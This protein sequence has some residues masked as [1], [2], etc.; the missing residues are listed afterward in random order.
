MGLGLTWSSDLDPGTDR[1][2]EAMNWKTW[3]KRRVGNGAGKGRTQSCKGQ[4][5]RPGKDAS[6]KGENPV[7]EAGSAADGICE[8]CQPGQRK[9]L[10]RVKLEG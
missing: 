2:G 6:E 10:F 1:A 4:D 8:K 9:G 7:M 5:L 3:Q